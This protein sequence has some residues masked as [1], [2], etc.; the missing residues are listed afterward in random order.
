[1]H[2]CISRRTGQ[3]EQ[4]KAISPMAEKVLHIFSTLGM[5]FPT[6]IPVKL[7]LGCPPSL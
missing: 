7:V 2:A 4:A 1:M 3:K 6:G 5:S